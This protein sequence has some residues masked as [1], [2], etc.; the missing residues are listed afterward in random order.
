MPRRESVQQRRAARTPW[1][2]AGAGTTTSGMR[3]KILMVLALVVGTMQLSR[4]ETRQQPLWE[5]GLGIDVVTF[6]DYP[7]SNTSRVWP[8]PVVYLVYNGTF[9]KADRNGVR[10]LLINQEWVELNVSG[11]LSPPVR[12]ITTGHWL[13]V[14]ASVDTAQSLGTQGLRLAGGNRLCLD[15][16]EIDTPRRG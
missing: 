8:V 11:D 9:L 5:Y 7:G 3:C 6:Q 2:P 10:G 15:A 14:R 4:A 1:V 16:R 12:R 13:G